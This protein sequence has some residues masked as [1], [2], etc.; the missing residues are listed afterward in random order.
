MG[1]GCLST[2]CMR[3]KLIIQ[4]LIIYQ[5]LSFRKHIWFRN[6]SQ[7]EASIQVTNKLNRKRIDCK[8]T[9]WKLNMTKEIIISNRTIPIQFETH[10]HLITTIIINGNHWNYES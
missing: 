9:K 5:I 6:F 8:E 2:H 1:E 10:Y 4:G 3:T 7:L